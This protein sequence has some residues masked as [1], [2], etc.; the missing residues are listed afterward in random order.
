M[1]KF[2]PIA[3]SNLDAAAYDAQTGEL[4]VK[5]KNGGAYRYENVS[6]ELFDKFRATFDPE[7]GES[8]GRFFSQ[9]IRQLP[10]EKI[11]L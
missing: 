2:I 11:E 9:N 10:A 5:F 1:S 6:P 8:A 7:S 3:S 4:I